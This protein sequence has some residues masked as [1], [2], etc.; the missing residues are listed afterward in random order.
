MNLFV[1]LQPPGSSKLELV[2][3]PLD[4][5]VLPGVTRASVLELARERLPTERYEVAERPITIREV[6]AAAEEGRLKE[7]FGTGTAVVIAPVRS[8]G[9]RRQT[10]HCGLQESE[11]QGEV[12]RLMRGWIEE[13]QYGEVEHEWSYLVG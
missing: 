3:P 5:T 4:G 6:A 8:I 2:T 11:E 9:W 1:L 12:A 7:V 10:V 13:I